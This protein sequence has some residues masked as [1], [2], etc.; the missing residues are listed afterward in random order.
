MLRERERDRLRC[1]V[2]AAAGGMRGMRAWGAVRA[3]H[4]QHIYMRLVANEMREAMRLVEKYGCEG[5]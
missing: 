2:A 5:G 4:V 1:A 3:P